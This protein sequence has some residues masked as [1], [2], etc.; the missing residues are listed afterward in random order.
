MNLREI[1]PSWPLYPAPIQESVR[2]HH[3]PSGDNY[4][5]LIFNWVTTYYM[6]D[7]SHM[8]CFRIFSIIFR[9]CKFL[10]ILFLLHIM[11]ISLP[12]WNRFQLSVIIER[13]D[14]QMTHVRCVCWVE[15]P[16]LGALQWRIYDNCLW[17]Q[18][19]TTAVMLPKQFN[20]QV[21][22]SVHHFR[23]R[24]IASERVGQYPLD[25]TWTNKSRV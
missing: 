18:L 1:G 6:N 16:L 21:K 10:H 5:A 15:K 3:L 12:N 8:I 22:V 14:E 17:A 11:Y 24:T 4:A 13:R 2:G 7:Q 19:S 23:L 25:V 9:I 20:R